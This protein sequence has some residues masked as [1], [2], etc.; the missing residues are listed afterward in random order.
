[1]DQSSQMW[2]VI[3]QTALRGLGKM[4]Y[5]VAINQDHVQGGMRVCLTMLAVASNTQ[6]ANMMCTQQQVLTGH[7]S[8]P[9]NSAVSNI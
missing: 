3:F 9:L 5:L 6:I 1:M 4:L 7:E 8:Q 2:Q